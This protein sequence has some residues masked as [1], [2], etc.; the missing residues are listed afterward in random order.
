M[1][2]RFGSFLRALSRNA[3]EKEVNGGSESCHPRSLLLQNVFQFVPSG[4][5]P[6]VPTLSQV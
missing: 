1:F 4:R 2:L 6:R 3:V 5:G